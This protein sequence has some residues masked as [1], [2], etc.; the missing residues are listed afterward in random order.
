MI[1]EIRYKALR[2]V[3]QIRMRDLQRMEREWG[4]DKQR[5][6]A[7]QSQIKDL[8]E[9]NCLLKQKFDADKEREALSTLFESYRKANDEL[10]EENQEMKKEINKILD[11]VKKK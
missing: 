2:H 3:H 6:I 5:L 7:I 8:K 11:L 9:E 1:T 10:W 4:K